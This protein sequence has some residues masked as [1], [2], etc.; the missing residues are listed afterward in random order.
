MKL[1]D[2]Y[3]LMRKAGINPC[4]SIET[5][6]EELKRSKETILTRD[7]VCGLRISILKSGAKTWLTNGMEDKEE[8]RHLNHV[9]ISLPS[10][11]I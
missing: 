7:H 2:F 1:E 4:F 11:T 5:V 9:T 8:Y 3:E 10:N 6:I